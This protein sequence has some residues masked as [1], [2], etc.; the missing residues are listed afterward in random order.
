MEHFTDIGPHGRLGEGYSPEGKKPR[1]LGFWFALGCGGLLL[2]IVVFIAAI[3]AFVF[4][5]MRSSDAFQKSFAMVRQNEA[6]QAQLGTP[7]EAGWLIT[8]HIN[9]DGSS[10][11]ADLRYPVRGPKGDANVHA[12]A[13]KSG[14]EWRF[15]VLQV[16]GDGW[17]LDLL[18]PEAE[19]P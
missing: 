1:S 5:S 10:G 9:I 19:V 15:T 17:E 6:V 7:I 8:G 13:E 14:G 3:F 12:R 2:L 4:G 11:E 16:S 18:Q